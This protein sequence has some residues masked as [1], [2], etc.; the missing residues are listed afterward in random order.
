MNPQKKQT[1]K[2]LFCDI[3]ETCF[4]NDLSFWYTHNVDQISIRKVNL[5]A[6][7]IQSIE[8]ASGSLDESWH[9]PED[10]L[11]RILKEVNDYVEGK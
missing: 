1:I 2:D 6:T 7:D 11:N 4:E 9:D 3:A 10:V 8:V 5:T